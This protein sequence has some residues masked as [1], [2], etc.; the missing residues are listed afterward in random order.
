MLFKRHAWRSVGTVAVEKAGLD[1][2]RQLH[3]VTGVA[4]AAVELQSD[5]TWAGIRSGRY[6][7]GVG[8]AGTDETVEDP[9][10]TPHPP[11]HSYLW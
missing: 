9:P 5:R 10:P 11:Y 6:D 8:D 1:G 4:G 3:F 7:G 2:A